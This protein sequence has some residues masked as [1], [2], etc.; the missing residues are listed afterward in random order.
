M[1][2]EADELSFRKSSICCLSMVCI[3]DG[4]V[5]HVLQ[6]QSLGELAMRSGRATTVI[7]EEVPI[8]FFKLRYSQHWSI[9]DDTE[10]Y[11]LNRFDGSMLTRQQM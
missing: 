10:M 3:M 4:R 2:V 9:D 7:H 8:P 5:H 1:F 6:D 11:W